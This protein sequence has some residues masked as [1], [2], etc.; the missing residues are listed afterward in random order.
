M[1][2][3]SEFKYGEFKETSAFEEEDF[4]RS[5]LDVTKVK[6]GKT[7]QFRL[8]LIARIN[9]EHQGNSTT[10]PAFFDSLLQD[11]QGHLGIMTGLL[12]LYPIQCI[13][14]I[15]GAYESIQ[16]ILGAFSTPEKYEECVN[17]VKL[18][19]VSSNVQRHYKMFHKKVMNLVAPRV[20]GDYNSTEPFENLVGEVL[21]Q[22][23][24]IGRHLSG[25]SQMAA[26]KELESIQEKKPEAIV[27]QDLLGYLLNAKEVTS[28][29]EYCDFYKRTRRVILDENSVWPMRARLL[30]QIE[31]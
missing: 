15:E 12:L 20:E 6:T 4:R 10:I 13:A 31:Q 18:L 22:L 26:S 5:L 9:D 1:T 19:V 27:S 14:V 7:V 17:K 16:R 29:A 11:A 8:V 23:G 24:I 30:D 3:P 28:P 2:E 21:S 25:I